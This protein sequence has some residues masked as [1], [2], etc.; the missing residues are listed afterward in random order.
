M[1]T[2]YH[3]RQQSAL[4][5]QHCLNN[6][7]Q[8]PYFTEIDLAEIAQALDQKELALM[9][10]G[11]VDAETRKFMAQGSQN[12]ADD[13]NFSI[14]VLAEALRNSHNLTLED[15]RRPE[16]R[17]VI[18][19]PHWENGF[20]LNRS[21]HWYTVR[22]IN[23]TWWQI[24]SVKQL[25]EQL[26]ESHLSATLAQ[27]VA[28]NWTV[29][30]VRGDMPTPMHPNSGA[31]LA[32]N[33]V[34]TA[35]PAA[36]RLESPDGSAF[37][38]GAEPKKPSFVAFTGSGQTLGGSS[39]AAAAPPNNTGNMSE[40]EQLALAL[41]MSGDLALK[42]RLERRLPDEPADG[43]MAR[44]L[45]RMPDGSRASRK[46]PAESLLQSLV[47]FAVMQLA[48]SGTAARG[49]GRWQ[50][51]SQY[52][53]LKLA[54]SARTAEIEDAANEGLTFTSAG[55]APSAQLHLAAA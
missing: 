42:E 22:K 37:R 35:R 19:K 48:D 32:S 3:E 44:V 29:F 24:N 41:A 15:T 16:N 12:V 47:D 5:G 27:L 21:S 49:S 50:L 31:G 40:E 34:D 4:C 28:E 51:S 54:F 9:M 2:I 25:P 10:E 20:I 14:Q 23:G 33:W 11:G 38:N 46:F 13:G 1:P 55:L 8:G 53:P 43:P 17:A 7:L 30:V 52:P 39:T 36:D 26:T 45:I 18:T 6:L